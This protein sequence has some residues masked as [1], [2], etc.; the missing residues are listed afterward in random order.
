[1]TDDGHMQGDGARGAA[2]DRV[3]VK[4]GTEATD[5]ESAVRKVEAEG[6]EPATREAGPADI[7]SA[8]GESEA[9]GDEAVDHEPETADPH[10]RA[11]PPEARVAGI[12]EELTEARRAAQENMDR[13]LR[14][15]AELENVRRRMERDLQNAH[16][17]ALERF[18]AELLPVRDSLE[19][20]LAASAEKGASTAGITEGVE[21]TLRMLEQAME[22][23]GVR[24]VDPAGEPFDPDFHQAMTMQESDAA[25]SGTVLTVVQK[26]YLLNERLVRPAMVI[27]AK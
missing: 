27:V 24:V 10:S 5:D 11:E 4:D 13:A 12:V 22:K 19:L 21:L 23:F 25:A 14:V 2:G 1:M 9:V 15:Q 20:G 6:D 3:A 8:T 16:K 26:G 17:F 7:E 18:V